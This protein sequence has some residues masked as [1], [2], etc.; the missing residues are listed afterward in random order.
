MLHTSFCLGL[1]ALV[2][3]S[4]GAVAAANSNQTSPIACGVNTVSD[5][6]MM[7]VEG[8]FQSQTALTGEYR[9]SLRS[10]GNGGSSNISQGGAFSADAGA[11]I[12]LGKVMVNADSHF[13]IGFEVSAG[14][15]KYDCSQ[16]LMT[17]T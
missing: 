10:Q 8:I 15:R 17:R 5:R 11:T 1:V 2:A 13:N 16:P 4:G 12:I 3:I 14:G 7:S 9:F 6:G